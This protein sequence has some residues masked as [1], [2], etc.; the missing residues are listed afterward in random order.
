M[1]LREEFCAINKI[2]CSS[3]VTKVIV[4]GDEVMRV[5]P[6]SAWEVD[7]ILVDYS[8]DENPH[9]VLVVVFKRKCKEG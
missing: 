1:S 4:S 8:A 9:E 7:N 6:E 5:N 2:T 3:P